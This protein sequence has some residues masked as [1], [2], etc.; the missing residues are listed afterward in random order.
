MPVAKAIIDV[1]P[2]IANDKCASVFGNSILWLIL[3]VYFF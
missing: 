1:V 3:L 2:L